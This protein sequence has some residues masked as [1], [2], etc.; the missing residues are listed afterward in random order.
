MAQTGAPESADLPA[1]VPETPTHWTPQ[2][3]EASLSLSELGCSDG[4]VGM[5][6]RLQ[7]HF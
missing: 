5:L 4:G 3:G 7:V 6:A 1:T 2:G